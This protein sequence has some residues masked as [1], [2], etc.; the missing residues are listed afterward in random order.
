M[1]HI[2]MLLALALLTATLYASPGPV[3]TYTFRSVIGVPCGGDLPS[4]L[5]TAAGDA[6]AQTTK[7][8]RD[9]SEQ[10]WQLVSTTP[11][12]YAPSSEAVV[13][14]LRLPNLT[15]KMK[16]QQFQIVMGMSC[17]QIGPNGLP[18]QL[19][20]ASGATV[21]ETLNGLSMQ[22]WQLA[23]TTSCMYPYDQGTVGMAVYL[24]SK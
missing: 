18:S 3:P 11:V 17:R 23:S 9:Y 6:V 22:G 2:I 19:C 12:L 21:E 24:L 16:P 7:V 10:G 20:T 4:D 15:V 13:Y 1:K 8:L 14:L 5:C